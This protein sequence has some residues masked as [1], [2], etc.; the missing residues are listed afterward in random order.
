AFR[1]G[2][3]MSYPETDKALTTLKATPEHVWLNEVSSVCLQQSLRDLQTAFSNFFAKRAAYP[4]FKRKDARQS[5]NYT[6]RGFSF[7]REREILRVAGGG[8]S[9][10]AAAQNGRSGWYRLWCC[11]ACHIE[12][13]RA[14]QQPEARRQ[15]ATSA[16]VLS[17]APCQGE[18]GQ[19]EARESQASC[20]PHPRE[21]CQQ[22][23]R[24]A[25]QVEH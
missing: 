16:G 8:N 20:C 14:H 18:E 11:A 23:P 24:H 7:D 13:R 1:A 3:R 19:Q 17:E 15:V 22:S 12:Q 21:D 2:K 6:E 5:A 10:C 4:A 9:A 25:A